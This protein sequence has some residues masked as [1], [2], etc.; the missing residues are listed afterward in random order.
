MSVPLPA[1]PEAASLRAEP[2]A[3]EAF[4]PFGEVLG[5]DAA[6]SRS[7][8]AG[9]A[10]RHDTTARLGGAGGPVLGI[11]RVEPARLPLSLDTMERHPASSQAF[12][13]LGPPFLVVVA[14]E[15]GGL[16]DL[17]HARAFLGAA[18]QGINYRAG[19]WHAPITALGPGGDF[20]MLIWEQGTEEDCHVHALAR[21]VRVTPQDT[22]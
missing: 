10:R 9:T 22:P 18:G 4:G 11:Y 15:A 12:V 19:V 8:N 3:P 7:V 1:L 5:Y 16:P 20:L 21:P 13:S 14:P 2:L 6:A 17:R